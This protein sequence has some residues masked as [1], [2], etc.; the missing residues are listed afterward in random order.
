M[1]LL[2]TSWK[3]DDSSIAE[4]I[5]NQLF[6]DLGRFARTAFLRKSYHLAPAVARS[7][8]YSI[9]LF[10]GICLQEHYII[11]RF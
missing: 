4:E 9:C 11:L 2:M 7:E 1:S 10:V 3:S 8:V 5:Y 6:N